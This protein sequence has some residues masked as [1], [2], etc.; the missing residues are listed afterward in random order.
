VRSAIRMRQIELNTNASYDPI[1]GINR[2][3]PVVP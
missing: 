2:S 3:V 1:N